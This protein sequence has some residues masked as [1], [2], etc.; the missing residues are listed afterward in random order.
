MSFRDR[1]YE[2]ARRANRRIVFPEGHDPRVRAAGERI[3]ALR[4]GR[5]RVLD[6]AADAS[7]PPPTEL[8]Q[9][10]M[11]RRPDRFPSH[12]AALEALAQPIML[13]ACMVGAGLADVFVVVTLVRT[14]VLRRLGHRFRTIREQ[15][16]ERIFGQRVVILVRRS[17]NQAK[18]NALPI[19]DDAAL[20]AEL[21]AVD[22]A[23]AGKLPPKGAG[24][25]AVS[26]ICHSQS[27]PLSLSYLSRSFVHR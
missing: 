13:A 6:S 16:V 21:A 15:T 2:R 26:T 8:V 12:A 1:V 27:M 4:L 3:E 10:L 11:A 5:V 7:A 20:G 25:V 19:G 9:L 24:T 22:G 14:Q 18:G 23:G 17:Q